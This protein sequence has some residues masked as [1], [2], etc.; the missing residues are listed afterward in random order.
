MLLQYNSLFHAYPTNEL[1]MYIIA[2]TTA[3]H[4]SSVSSIIQRLPYIEWIA[5]ILTW[6]I[7]WHAVSYLVLYVRKDIILCRRS[8]PFEFDL[9][10][11][12][13]FEILS[14]DWTVTFL[15]CAF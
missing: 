14:V 3:R 7:L 11:N 12:S 5:F 1:V 8:D 10:S 4:R 9:Y 2:M 13:N 15:T 6:Y